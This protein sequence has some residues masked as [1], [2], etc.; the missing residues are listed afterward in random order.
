MVGVGASELVAVD[1]AAVLESVVFVDCRGLNSLGLL[2]SMQLSFV[3]KMIHEN[4]NSGK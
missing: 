2:V 4:A 1:C 3:V